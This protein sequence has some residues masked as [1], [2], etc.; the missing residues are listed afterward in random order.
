M[1]AGALL[2]VLGFTTIFVVQGVLFGT[3]GA[4]IR[5][6]NL[7]IQRVL[8]VV[9]IIM[10]IVFL[11]GFGRLQREFRV[12]KRPPLGLLGAPLLGAAFGLAWAPCLTPTFGTVLNMAY[13]EGTAGR[14]AFLMACY[15]I[16][17]G[18]PFLLV[19]LG[20]GWVTGALTFVRTHMRVISVI[21]GVLLI[22]IGL[23]LVTG[24]WNTWMDW[25]R[26]R[27]GQS[28]GVGSDL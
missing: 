19:A 16:G 10:G 3:L 22:A 23:A 8:G 25:L 14:G 17:L 13:T 28:S 27:F 18:V 7:L 21:G 15:C 4:S 2:F 6:H 5:D 9:T 11:G 12:H 1:V 24:E 20:F 26:A